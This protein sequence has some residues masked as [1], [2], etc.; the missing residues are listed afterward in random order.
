MPDRPA[1]NTRWT[2]VSQN[3]R[4]T[5]AASRIDPSSSR[6]WRRCSRASRGA[7]TL[8][9]GRGGGP[10]GRRARGAVVEV[11]EGGDAV[12]VGPGAAPAAGLLVVQEPAAHVDQGVP[13]A[14]GGAGGGFPVEV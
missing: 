4:W 10:A 1:T 11:V 12:E 2:P 3:S 14:L 5:V 9:W 7:M 8:R 6:P 13:A